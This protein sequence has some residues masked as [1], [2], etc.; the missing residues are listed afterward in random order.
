MSA[1]DGLGPSLFRNKQSLQLL[2][3]ACKPNSRM[4]RELG[5]RADLILALISVGLPATKF[6]LSHPA[7]SYQHTP[8]YALRPA[9]FGPC[10]WAC[11]LPALTCTLLP[12]NLS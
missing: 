2:T 6:S 3:E 12:T 1:A 10:T 5:G 4:Y 7:E 8:T 9:H 11:T